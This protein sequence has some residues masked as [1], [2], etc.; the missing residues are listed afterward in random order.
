MVGD[1][2]G[3]AGAIRH[4]ISRALLK[5]D[6]SL[7][8]ELKK[9]WLPQRRDPRMKEKER[10]NMVLK[11]KKSTSVFKEIILGYIKEDCYP[12]LLFLCL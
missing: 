12:H 1:L 10:N 9:S 4:G 5:A 6:E 3:Q 2:Q 11:G 8:P 7:K